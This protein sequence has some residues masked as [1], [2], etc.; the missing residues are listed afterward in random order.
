[1]T[2]TETGIH[3]AIA[4]CGILLALA[5]PDTMPQK[6]SNSSAGERKWSGGYDSTPAPRRSSTGIYGA[7]VVDGDSLRVDGKAVRLWGIDAPELGQTCR[8]ASGRSWACGEAAAASLRGMIE[9]DPAVTCEP[10]DRD[11]YG[12]LVALCRNSLGDLGAMQVARGMAVAYTRYSTAY[13]DHEAAARAE[14]LGLWAG[15]FTM[16]EQHR[17]ETR[18]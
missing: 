14:K 2:R 5:I 16:P 9:R 8:D 15:E 3:A 17:K 7:F 12:R 1:M 18:R 10:K 13:A 6:S 11:R 4:G